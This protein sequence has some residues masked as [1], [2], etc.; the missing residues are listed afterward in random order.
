MPQCST[1]GTEVTI[2]NFA[3]L[4]SLLRSRR[5]NFWKAGV[6]RGKLM[7]SPRRK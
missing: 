7:W 1:E 3:S 5:R 4:Y 2:W 6:R